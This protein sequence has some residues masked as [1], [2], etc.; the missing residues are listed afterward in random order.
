MNSSSFASDFF[1]FNY[2]SWFWT[3]FNHNSATCVVQINAYSQGNRNDIVAVSF[4]RFQEV[5]SKHQ[6]L[7][8]NTISAVIILQGDCTH[9]IVGFIDIFI[10]NEKS[11]SYTFICPNYLYHSTVTSTAKILEIWDIYRTN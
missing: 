11:S 1:H 7:Q 4:V 9:K 6:N 3:S 8:N 2:A 5:I 10:I